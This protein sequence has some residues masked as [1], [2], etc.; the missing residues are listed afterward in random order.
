[1]SYGSR[2]AICF[3]PYRMASTDHVPGPIIAN[4]E[5]RIA[6]ATGISAA[7]GADEAI[8]TSILAT[9]TPASGVHKPAIS[10]MPASAATL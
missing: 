8:K 4:V 7:V 10:R 5:L 9:S 1:M 3:L 6:N 2:N